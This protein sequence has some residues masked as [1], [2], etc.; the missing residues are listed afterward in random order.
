[1]SG[2]EAPKYEWTNHESKQQTKINHCIRK[3]EA[4]RSHKSPSESSE[5]S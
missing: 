2:K 3:Q 1:M 5:A 4:K